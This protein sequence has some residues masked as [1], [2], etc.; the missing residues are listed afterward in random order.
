MTTGGLPGHLTGTAHCVHPASVVSRALTHGA[1]K[2]GS[3][4]QTSCKF[5]VSDE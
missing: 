4:S 1:M 2:L 5:S 3:A